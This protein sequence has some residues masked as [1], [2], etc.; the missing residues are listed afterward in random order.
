VKL[1]GISAAIVLAISSVPEGWNFNLLIALIMV[2]VLYAIFRDVRALSRLATRNE[3][4]LSFDTMI[5]LQRSS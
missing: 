1:S 4:T 5:S 3:Q 2:I